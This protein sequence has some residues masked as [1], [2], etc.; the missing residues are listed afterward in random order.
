M[1]SHQMGPKGVGGGVKND[2]SRRLP[3]LC[4]M[5]G[6]RISIKYSL[7]KWCPNSVHN[8]S[9]TIEIEANWW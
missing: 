2:R 9:K 6:V 5:R 8:G 4:A 7:S 3:V 1:E